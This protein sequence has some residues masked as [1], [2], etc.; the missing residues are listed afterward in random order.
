MSVSGGPEPA[1]KKLFE[2]L[3]VVLKR[4]RVCLDFLQT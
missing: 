2:L 3:N 4:N 1:K